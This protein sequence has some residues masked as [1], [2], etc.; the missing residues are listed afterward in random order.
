M[1]ENTDQTETLGEI[2][3]EDAPTIGASTTA[4][5]EQ[6]AAAVQSRQQ[7]E[8]AADP[9]APRERY[10]NRELSWLAFNER[11]LDEACNPAHPLLE[12]LRFLSISGN[13]LDEFFMVRVAGLR[14]QQVNGVEQLSADGLTP[15]QQLAA[16][17][18]SADRLMQ[19]QQEVRRVLRDELATRDF[20]ILHGHG[21]HED[22]AEWLEAYFREQVLPVLTPQALDPAH[23]FPF[24]PN[25]G[26]SL[27]F[28]LKRLSDGEPIRELLMVPTTLV[29]LRAAA[30][31]RGALRRDR[32]DH[33][34]L[35]RAALP[36]LRSARRRRVPR[37]PRQRHR[38]RGGG[39]GPRPLLSLRDQAAPPRQGHPAADRGGDARAA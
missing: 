11:V 22:E 35:H 14:G 9:V 21:I 38:D 26:F 28:D 12:R 7:D 36:R 24:I 2:R 39:G 3:E 1:T 30:R 34:P 4:E 6:A 33:P 18:E 20:H 27:V 17:A 31:R 13:N 8:P 15:A 16:I 25:K 32:D 29:A 23:P 37:D 5:I 10:F 19:R